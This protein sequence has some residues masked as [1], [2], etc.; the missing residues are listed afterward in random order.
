[1]KFLN[2]INKK[3]II[4]FLIFVMIISLS[5]L[6]IL[7]YNKNVNK[8]ERIE[9]HLL[10]ADNLSFEINS[11]VEN[12]N[13]LKNDENEKK[14][15]VLLTEL[16]DIDTSKL[17]DNTYIFGYMYK[18]SEEKTQE[19]K[20]TVVDTTKPE[21]KSEDKFEIEAGSDLNLK[22][23]VKVSDN[24]KEE[25][26]LKV[27]GEYDVKTP[28]EYKVKLIAEDS[29]KNKSEKEITI[30]VNNKQEVAE[31]KQNKAENNSTNNN[32]SNNKK[33]GSSGNKSNSNA[34]ISNN[35]SQSSSGYDSDYLM[36]KSDELFAE[37]KAYGNQIKT[38]VWTYVPN[39]INSHIPGATYPIYEADFYWQYVKYGTMEP[40]DGSVVDLYEWR[41]QTD[42]DGYRDV[43]GRPQMAHKNAAKSY[44]GSQPSREGSP[45][46]KVGNVHLYYTNGI[47]FYEPIK[48]IEAGR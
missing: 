15:Y 40:G 25:L 28:G 37:G 11:K 35:N 41:V 5:I 19:I 47:G 24:S 38:K 30:K 14:G 18:N 46:E 7:V 16:E 31:N 8:K 10:I 48:Y 13:L 36:K 21:I 2:K 44:L 12:V 4:L 9:D 27:E 6:G 22:D 26:E 42:M 23:L 3:Y 29:S 20:Y 32:K 43:T 17:G 1:M 45:N 33:S 34:N 39:E